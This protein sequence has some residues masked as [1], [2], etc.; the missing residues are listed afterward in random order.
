[1]PPSPFSECNSGFRRSYQANELGSER[2]RLIARHESRPVTHCVTVRGNVR[3]YE[4]ETR[5]RSL[6]HSIWLP[7]EQ[8]GHREH[9]GGFQPLQDISAINGEMHVVAKPSGLD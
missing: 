1:M 4:R 2:A 3:Q 6:E 8:T 7:L 5:C 9:V